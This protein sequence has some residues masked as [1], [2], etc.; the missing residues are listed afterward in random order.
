MCV[1]VSVAVWSHV[2][3]LVEPCSVP[4]A[5]LPHPHYRARATRVNRFRLFADRERAR[6]AFEVWVFGPFIVGR[7]L[8]STPSGARL[9]MTG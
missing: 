1:S 2:T 8:M 6:A 5:F 3:A 7:L 9:V 4:L